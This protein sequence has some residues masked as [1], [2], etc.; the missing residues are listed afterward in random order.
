M[1][2][3]RNAMSVDNEQARTRPAGILQYGV[4]VAF[5]GMLSALVALVISIEVVRR[6]LAVVCN[7]SRNQDFVSLMGVLR[8][9]LSHAIAMVA[10]FTGL[11]LVLRPGSRKEVRRL[12]LTAGNPVSV[13]LGFACF[14][15]IYSDA[16]HEYIVVAT[17][18]ITALLLGPAASVAGMHLARLIRRSGKSGT[19]Q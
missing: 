7:E 1:A 14:Y 18:M 12:G 15:F 5:L 19:T 17:W 8:A 13:W 9:L 3:V 4:W 6:L 11:G 16:P 10:V 2:R